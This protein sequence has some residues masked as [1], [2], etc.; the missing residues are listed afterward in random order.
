MSHLFSHG[1]L[2]CKKSTNDI[3]II[4]LSVCIKIP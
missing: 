1:A 2:L 3:G 4:H